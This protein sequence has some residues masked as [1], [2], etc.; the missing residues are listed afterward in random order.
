VKAFS[1]P[2]RAH[3][4]ALLAAASLSAA[5]DSSAPLPRLQ[6][7][8][9]AHVFDVEVARTPQQR[10]L[11]LM[12]RTRLDDSAGMLFVFEQK[13]RHCFWMK[14]T[15]IPLSIAFLAD[16]GS[17]VNIEDMQP[18]TLGLHCPQVP[19]RH[20]LEVKQGGF[21]SRGIQPGMGISGGPFGPRRE[22]K[23]SPTWFP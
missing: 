3:L 12:G 11:G 18:N 9:G 1:L 20:A 6:L 14:N 16:D 2:L 4:A 7:H 8:A 19:V 21:R 10:K 23:T 13:A 17:I 5:A 15:P 22:L